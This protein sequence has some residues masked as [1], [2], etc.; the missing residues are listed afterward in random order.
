MFASVLQAVLLFAAPDSATATPAPDASAPTSTR[1]SDATIDRGEP[2][3]GLSDDYTPPFAAEPMALSEVLQEAVERNID[4]ALNAFDIHI[5]EARVLAAMGVYDVFLLAGVDASISETPRRGS[6]FAFSLAQ[7]SISA[8]V[9]FRRALESGGSISLLLTAARTQTDQ[10]L[11]PFDTSQGATTVSQYAIRPTLQITHPLLQ[12][13]G[14]KVNRAPIDQARIATSQ[15]EAQRQLTAQTLARDLISAY[16]DLLFAHRDL[17][18]KR[19]SVALAQRQLERTQA[20]VSAGRLSPVD[21]KAVEQGVVARESDAIVAENN[22]LNASITIRTY[23]GQQFTQRKVLGLWPSTDPRVEPRRVDVQLEIDKAL[24]A[25]PQIR[26]LELSLASYRIEE[27][28]ASNQRLPRL[29]VTGTFSPQGR[30]ADTLPSPSEGSAG[31]LATWPEAFGNFFNRQVATNGILADWT[32]TGSLSLTWDIQNRGPRGNHEAAKL[33]LERAEVQLYQVQQTVS[34][35]VILAANTLRTAAKVLEVS[36]VSLDL[37]EEN[38]AAEQARFEVGRSTNFDVL[39]RLDEVD[40]A[41]ATALNARIG[42]LKGIVQLQA[43][44]GEILPAFG[45][46]Q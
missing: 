16:W 39:L 22:L 30:S 21:A 19:R 20:L 33:Q 46:T 34:A 41:A 11:N 38:L 5:S 28:V 23:M 36:D 7:R 2:Q 14:I 25:N 37:A 29:D 13:L 24:K 6:Q 45:L 17:I 43:L 40:A 35:N 18:N 4:L 9:G 27:L 15:A 3:L 10:P 44:T 8:N 12:G 31:R 26:Q 1:V 32:L 42:Y